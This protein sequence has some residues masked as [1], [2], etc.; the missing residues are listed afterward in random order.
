MAEGE[1]DGREPAAGRG[2]AGAGARKGEGVVSEPSP[3]RPLSELSDS[4]L[5][6][7]INR[8]VFHP[9]GFALQLV[10]DFETGEIVGWRLS[11]DGTQAWHMEGDEP[12]FEST[13]AT[14]AAAKA[15]PEPR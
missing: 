11:G 2:R 3:P 6:W 10:K 5:L 12:E 8:V 15:K 1:W 13:E 14:F 9:R 7:L 4:G